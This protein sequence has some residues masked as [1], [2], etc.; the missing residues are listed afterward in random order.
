MLFTDDLGRGV[1]LRVYRG[2]QDIDSERHLAQYYSSKPSLHKELHQAKDLIEAISEIVDSLGILKVNKNRITES[3]AELRQPQGFETTAEFN[4]NIDADIHNYLAAAYSFQ[5]IL[6]TVKGDLYTDG[7]VRS[8]LNEFE[9]EKRVISGLRIYVQ[10]YLTLPTS[11]RQYVDP[12]TGNERTSVVVNLEDIDRIESDVHRY[13]PDGYKKSVEHH[14]GDGVK[15]HYGDVGPE[16]IDIESHVQSHYTTTKEL[17][18]EICSY[19]QSVCEAELED[20]IDMT[21]YRNYFDF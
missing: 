2:G 4:Q 7:T 5:M 15:R 21:D 11:Y 12:T 13:P 3:V 17:A 8:K 20:Y 16:F 18:L 9:D 14:Y 10:H 1:R 19:A 6:N